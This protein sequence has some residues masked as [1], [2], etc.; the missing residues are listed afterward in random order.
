[1]RA[2]QGFVRFLWPITKRSSLSW[3]GYFLSFVLFALLKYKV[4]FKMQNLALS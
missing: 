4:H 3:S 1:M 2:S